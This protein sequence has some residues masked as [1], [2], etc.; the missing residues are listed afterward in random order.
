MNDFL[1]SA[2][3]VLSFDGEIHVALCDGQGGTNAYSLV[4]W[5]QSWMAAE[6]AA[7]SNL[8]L[9]DVSSFE[10]SLE[11]YCRLTRKIDTY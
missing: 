7:M 4:E 6:Y 1:K 8:L 3:E 2:S 10:V 9:A 5:R 11:K